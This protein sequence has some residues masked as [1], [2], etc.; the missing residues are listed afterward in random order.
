MKVEEFIVVTDPKKGAFVAYENED[1][2]FLK[3]Y[4]KLLISSFGDVI[5]PFG[6]WKVTVVT[7]YFGIYKK[8]IMEKLLMPL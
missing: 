7:K 2:V 8:A 1:L 5:F 4:K 3:K 6:F